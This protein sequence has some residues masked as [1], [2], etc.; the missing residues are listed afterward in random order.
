MQIYIYKK[1]VKYCYVFSVDALMKIGKLQ[2]IY[3]NYNFNYNT[4]V[5]LVQKID[6]L[7][8]IE[9]LQIFLKIIMETIIL[10]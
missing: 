7:T 10:A 8:R 3:Y 5:L 6:A 9:K 1:V 4:Y 2:I